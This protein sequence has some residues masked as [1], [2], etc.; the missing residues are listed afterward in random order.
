MTLASSVL[1]LLIAKGD[2]V[3]RFWSKV[4][5]TG[6]CWNWTAGTF[7]FGH[8]K[9][10]LNGKM[11]KAHRLA[12]ELLVGDFD[13]SLCVLHKCDNPRCV[14]PEH[15]F[16]G[17]KGDNNS[18]MTAKGR[19]KEQLKTHCPSGHAYEGENLY[20]DPQRGHRQCRLCRRAAEARRNRPLV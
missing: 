16:L 18:D 5:K 7:H 19:H 12:Y 8:G 17:T 6:D 11:V 13:K 2:S 4:D 15:L 3:E 10:R 14:N 20:V 1:A 9:F